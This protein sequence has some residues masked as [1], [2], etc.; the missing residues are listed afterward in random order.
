ML[1]VIGVQRAGEPNVMRKILFS[2]VS[3]LALIGLAAPA[4][5]ASVAPSFGNIVTITFTGTVSSS[6]DPDGIFGCTGDACSNE[7]YDGDTYTAVFTFN[8]AVG[9][10]NDLAATLAFAEGGSSLPP[11]L[12]FGDPAAPPPSPLVGN[13]TVTVNGVTYDLPGD[14]YAI[15]QSQSNEQDT[16]VLPYE[17]IA[18]VKDLSGNEIYGFV[19]TTTDPPQFPV[20]IS[21]PFSADFGSAAYSYVNFDCTSGGGCFG[22]IQGDMSV[23]LVDNSTVPEPSTWVMM[24]VGFAGLAFAGYRR[25]RR[26]A[27]AA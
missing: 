16:G 23:S 22:N 26:A 7:P 11:S 9:Y 10:T 15:L 19:N 8:D 25:T 18:H 21:T 13:A 4:G 24:G 5:A 12:Q 2:A 20:S 14:Y 1:T 17:I 3:G 27:P 6:D